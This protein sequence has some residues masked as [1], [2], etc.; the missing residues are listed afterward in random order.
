MP[1]GV[2]LRRSTIKALKDAFLSKHPDLPA[3]DEDEAQL[4][5]GNQQK[6]VHIFEPN[7]KVLYCLMFC[8][9]IA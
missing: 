6:Q 3:D 8:K 5:P 2:D 9:K 4:P 1:N 7:L